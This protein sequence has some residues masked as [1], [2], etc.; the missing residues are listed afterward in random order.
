MRVEEPRDP[1]KPEGWVRFKVSAGAGSRYVKQMVDGWQ[2]GYA[3]FHI[4]HRGLPVL[5]FPPSHKFQ[6]ARMHARSQRG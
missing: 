4:C 1:E 3:V 2:E 6:H 5:P